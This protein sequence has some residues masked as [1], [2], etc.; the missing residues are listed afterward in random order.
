MILSNRRAMFGWLGGALLLSSGAGRA[1]QASLS[2]GSIADA[3]AALKPGEFIWAPDVAPDGP[4]MI[5]VSLQTQ[6]AYVY[7]NG[8]IIGVSTVSTGKEGHETPT[9]V[10]TVLQKAK[11]H[12]SN[13]YNNAPMPFM[14]RLTWDGIALHAGNLPGYPASH[15][16]IRLPMAFARQLYGATSLG[17]TVVITDAHDVPRVAPTPA[18]LAGNA[19]S[20]AND[21]RA[22]WQIDKAA[23]GPISIIISAS[24]RRLLVLRNGVEIGRTPVTISGPV[25]GASAYTLRAKDDTGFHWLQ[26]PLPG[27]AVEP[28]QELSAEER[29]R[30]HIP[31]DF[32]VRLAAM[33]VPGTTVVLTSDTLRSGGSGRKMTVIAGDEDASSG[34]Q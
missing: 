21:D 9:G 2:A 31:E 5:I 19:P 20:A 6:R 17:L 3:V 25:T 12:K 29:E 14:Q 10:F 13:L 24:D 18:V 11:D 33:L 34:G 30:L 8:V 26:L 15:G 16:C 1:M 4:V 22:R 23:T 28:G 32:R 7:R 27:Q